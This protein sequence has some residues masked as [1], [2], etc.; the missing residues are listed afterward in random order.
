M[1]VQDA[2]AQFLFH[3]QYEKNLSPKTLKAYSID[4]RQFREYLEA[5]LG[6]TDFGAIDKVVLRAFIK[7]LFGDLADKS[8]K[9]KVATLK[10]LFHHLER[11]ARYPDQGEEATPAD[12][13][14]GRP[15][16]ALPA[17]LPTQGRVAGPGVAGLRGPG[18]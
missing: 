15:G 13:L 6:L 14:P 3:C 16:A 10:S 1:T 18:P 7:S 17:R 5:E 9:R 2:I 8:V 4:L 12:D 11:E